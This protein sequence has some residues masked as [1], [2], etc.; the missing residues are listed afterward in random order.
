MKAGLS[1]PY[2]SAGGQA[3]HSIALARFAR[4]AWH[5]MVQVNMFRWKIIKE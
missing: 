3:Q 1:G 2:A 5:R 4:T